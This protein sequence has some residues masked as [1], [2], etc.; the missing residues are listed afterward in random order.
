MGI[1]FKKTFDLKKQNKQKMFI[2]L[3]SFLLSFF[4]VHFYSTHFSRYVFVKG[5]HIHHFYFGTV[6]LFLGG[7]LGV[8]SVGERKKKIAAALI[9]IGT[10]LFADEIGMLLNCTTVDRQCAYFFPDTPD[11]IMII[12]VL[13]VFLIA[14]ADSDPAAFRDRLLA[15]KTKPE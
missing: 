13:I 10:G 6:A 15:R 12:T 9:G 5:Y 4:V 11:I 7:I 8:L 14:M 1:K 2:V 3:V